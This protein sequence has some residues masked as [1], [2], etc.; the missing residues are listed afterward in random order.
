VSISNAALVVLV[1][2]TCR[3]LPTALA[4]RV[5]CFG[6]VCLSVRPFVYTLSFEAIDL[7]TWFF[8]CIWIMTIARRD[9]RSRS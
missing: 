4:E 7:W 2:S 6:R 5:M 9:W 1:S 8:A 3:I